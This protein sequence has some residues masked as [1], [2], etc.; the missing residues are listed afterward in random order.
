MSIDI[1]QMARTIEQLDKRVRQLENKLD[2][3]LLDLGAEDALVT[4]PTATED[5]TTYEANVINEGPYVYEAT[6][7]N[8]GPYVY[9]PLDPYKSEIRLLA[10]YPAKGEAD[11]IICKLQRV[12]LESEP[13]PVTA[14]SVDRFKSL[15][16]RKYLSLSGPKYNAL[17]YNWGSLEKTGQIVLNG[18][19]FPV[20]TNLEAAL[21]QFRQISVNT[22]HQAKWWIDAICVNQDD[23]LERNSQVLFMRRI[24]KKANHVS[25]WLGE[26]A[27]DSSLALDTI[28]KLPQPPR[29]APG[30]VE[31]KISKISID[32][33]FRRWKALWALYQRPWFKRVWVRQE[34]ALSKNR[35]VY[36]GAYSCSFDSLRTATVFLDH[37]YNQLMYRPLPPVY[38]AL[39]NHP[40]RD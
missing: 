18:H 37:V 20:T 4:M 39:A 40:T 35:S 2:S 24:F 31:P 15:E 1:S 33:K 5:Y 6:V 3:L 8:E 11:P 38:L 7:I 27:E 34:A 30:E 29:R 23:V 22:V 16:V 21:R 13:A 10:L 9:E 12:E 32:E 25:I 17:S 26:E 28:V 14:R 36:C 19:I